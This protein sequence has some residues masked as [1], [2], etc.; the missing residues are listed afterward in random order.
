MPEVESDR[1]G[2]T[3]TGQIRSRDTDDEGATPAHISAHIPARIVVEYY[4]DPLCSWSWAFEPHWRRLRYEFGDQL[5]WRYRMGGLIPDWTRYDDP[6][7]SISRPTQMGPQWFEVRELTG[8]PFDERLWHEDPPA[9]SFPSC[10]AVKAAELQGATAAERYLR[11]LRE[12]VMAERRNVARIETLLALAGEVSDQPGARSPGFDAERFAHDLE[13]PPAA[14]AFR[15]DLRDAGYR[16]IG[17]FP[18][19]TLWPADA[20]GQLAT[21]GILIVGYRPY[22][23]VRE[24]LV[25]LDRHLRPQRR[26]LDALTYAQY[27]GAVAM[28]EVAAALEWSAPRA[29][30]ALAELVAAGRLRERGPFFEAVQR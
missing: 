15:Q 4:T 26:A 9:S 23:V 10:V 14:E 22:D 30:E 28:P 21:R 8:M 2:G 29:S 18:T 20:T 13:Q 16:G 7:H 25:A 6:I 3:S 12:A 19:L 1:I 24:A 17:R 11:R 5:R 27:W